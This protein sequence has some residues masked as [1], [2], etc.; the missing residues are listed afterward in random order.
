E[1]SESGE[2]GEVGGRLA[3]DIREASAGQDMVRI[4]R[5]RADFTAVGAGNEISQHLG[6]VDVDRG[7]SA[8]DYRPTCTADLA[9]GTADVDHAVRRHHDR[10]HPT[11]GPLNEGIESLTAVAVDFGQMTARRRAAVAIGDIGEI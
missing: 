3:A 7:E 5:E 4:R 6:A 2:R 9:E 1:R 8:G 10:V 11:V